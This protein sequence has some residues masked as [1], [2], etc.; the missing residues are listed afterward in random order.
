[1]SVSIVDAR[2]KLAAVLAPVNETDPPVHETTPDAIVPPCIMLGWRIPMIEWAER[3]GTR[4]MAFG[5]VAV[6]LVGGRLDVAGGIEAIEAMYDLVQR[7]M[8]ADS[9]GWMPRNDEGIGPLEVGNVLYLAARI[10]VRV[11]LTL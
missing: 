3:S 4:C 9:E 1:M 11:P 8:R 5:L 7:R 6:T 2:S 10:E